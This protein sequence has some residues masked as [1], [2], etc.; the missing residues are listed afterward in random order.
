M[1]LNFSDNFCKFDKVFACSGGVITSKSSACRTWE[2]Y[3]S[4]FNTFMLCAL[5]LLSY[6]SFTKPSLGFLLL[7]LLL[8]NEDTFQHYWDNY[9][10]QFILS[11]GLKNVAIFINKN[12]SS[13]KYNQEIGPL[14]PLA[15]Y[16]RDSRMNIVLSIKNSLL[17]EVSLLPGSKESHRGLH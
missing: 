15:S 5:E 17:T 6:I 3:K 4:I 8:L 2:C 16:I 7:T 14:I 9:W 1:H 11:F 12:R 13:I 10:I